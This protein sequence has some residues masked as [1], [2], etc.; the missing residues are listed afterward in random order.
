MRRLASGSNQHRGLLDFLI[1]CARDSGRSVF[2]T[3]QHRN[4]QDDFLVS[5]R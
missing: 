2:L 3:Q 5:D 1:V 4:F